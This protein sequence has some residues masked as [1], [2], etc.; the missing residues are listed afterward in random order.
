M[1]SLFPS[2]RKAISDLSHLVANFGRRCW[3]YISN[4][5][6]SVEWMAFAVAEAEDEWR[7]RSARGRRNLR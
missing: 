6:G 3:V 2:G 5:P 4:Q 7:T 1:S